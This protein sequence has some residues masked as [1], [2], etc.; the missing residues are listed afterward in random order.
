MKRFVIS[1]QLKMK[2]LQAL[3]QSALKG[4]VS[5]AFELSQAPEMPQP[6]EDEVKKE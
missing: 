4:A 6:K 3:D 1:E 2:L 5:L